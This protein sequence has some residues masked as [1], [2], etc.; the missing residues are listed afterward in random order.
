MQLKN[1]K[2]IKN[3]RPKFNTGDDQR[4]FDPG[5]NYIG[6][7]PIENVQFFPKSLAD[8]NMGKA[9]SDFK[10][11][12]IKP[13]SNGNSFSFPKGGGVA[14]SVTSAANF[15]GDV[16]SNFNTPAQSANQLMQQAGTS[17]NAINGVQYD[18]Y[19]SIDADQA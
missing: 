11:P 7:D 16:F 17:Q 13:A 8:E 6:F 15:L 5:Y 14:S 3:Q 9:F 12:P 1:Y 4:V 2:Y 18:Q 19:N 10:A